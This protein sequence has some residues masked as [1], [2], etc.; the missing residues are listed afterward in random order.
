VPTSGSDDW[1]RFLERLKV[2][3]DLHSIVAATDPAG[4]IT[5]A[6]DR[7]LEVSGYTREELLGRNHRI[8][9]SGHHP[10]SFYEG[11]WRTI[12][13]GEVWRGEVCNRAKSGRLYWVDTT[14]VPFLDAQGRPQQFLSLRTEVTRLKETEN[15]LSG[16]TH[17]LERRV[18]SRTAELGEVNA[19]LEREI[20]EHREAA[21]KLAQS[22][23]LYR[24]LFQSVSD[25]FYT[26]E[27]R[28]GK[29]FRTEHTGGC[30][31]VTGYTPE[32]FSKETLLWIKMV[33]PDDRAAV[34]AQARA[35][36]EGQSPPPL[37]HRIIRKDGELR[38]IRNTVVVRRDTTGRVAFYDG[39]ISD[40]T[41]QRLAQQ[42]IEQLNQE[43]EQRVAD[44]TGE[45]KARNDQFRLLFEHAPVGISWVEWGDPDIYRLNER[46]C[47]I[48]G[49]TAKEAETF[50]NIMAAT[51]PDDRDR[52]RRL[53]QE[54]WTG[55]RDRF[56]M[57][58]RYVHKDGRV[59]WANLTVVVLRDEKRKII[60]Q[61][62]MLEDITERRE[63]E[64]RLR[65][66][67]QRFR[68]F[69][70][71]A[72]EILYSLSPDGHFLYVSPTWTT[73]LGHPVDEVTGQ[74][75][76]RFIHPDDQRLFWDFL[77]HVLEHGRSTFSV[78]YRALD[79]GG[80]YRWHASSGAAY[81]DESGNKV[82]MGVARDITDRKRSQVELRAA[83]AHREEMARI[84]DRSP[85][86]VVL[87]RAT[88]TWPVEFVS[89]NVSQFGYSPEEILSGQVTFVTILHPEDRD[90]VVAEVKAH[91]EAGH[92]EYR[93]EYRIVTR[94]GAVRWIDDRTAVRAGPDGRVTHHEGILT[95]ITER[96]EA[97]RRDEEMRERDLRTAREVQRHLLPNE[98]PQVA[99]IEV[100]GLYLPSRHIGGD[101]YDYFE[102]GPRRWAFVVADVSGKGASAALV[103]AACRMALRVEAS[104]LLSP[105]ALLRHVNH[106]I[107]PD[108][109]NGMYISVVFCLLDLDARKLTIARAGH[110][111]PI[112]IRGDTGAAET[113]SPSGLAVGLDPGA[114]FDESLEETT[115]E[116]QPGDMLV[117]YTD[118]ITEAANEADAE[119]GRERLIATV[120][121]ARTLPIH[122]VVHRVDEALKNFIGMRAPG[123]DRTLVI[124]RMRRTS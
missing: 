54:L 124:V 17:D 107:Y 41:P 56:A 5:Y 84:I 50:E 15:A 123:D 95:D 74:P 101:Y 33:V 36:L 122:T 59:I 57:E 69:V 99:E 1:P 81:F 61:F 2:A 77:R 110:E 13:R 7:F 86:V 42:K 82:Y 108:V 60:Q 8:L 16:L 92:R 11:M 40:I 120:A 75:V 34:E 121:H 87:W 102:M 89:Q 68:R 25:Y 67:E 21:E 38:W 119:F 94:D 30:T 19:R 52:Q 14:I 43:L 47:Q 114:I 63:A 116:F 62:A 55:T 113:P 45:L 26:V 85:S 18:E 24:L 103:M 28:D 35:A 64:D 31:A 80:H 93:Q 9:K 48:I 96:R 98:Q 22:E 88:D 4:R 100:D 6:N 12:T 58:K 20:Q 118:G 49:L 117:L 46:F 23:S 83:L 109:P 76:S 3:I 73:K 90:R 10:H 105:A 79:R 66:S 72:N 91:A 32:E 115:V 97:E 112:V 111:A 37:E 53:I 44:R 51:H 104:R 106:L 29:A 39:I 65:R 71:N 27:V 70:E 78:E